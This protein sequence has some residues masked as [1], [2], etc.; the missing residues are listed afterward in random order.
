MV[1]QV[2]QVVPH[3]SLDARRVHIPGMLVDM[4]VVAG[5][6][7]PTQTIASSD[8]VTVTHYYGHVPNSP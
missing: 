4:V 8:E 6:A 3:G 2:A 5:A 1:V 7:M